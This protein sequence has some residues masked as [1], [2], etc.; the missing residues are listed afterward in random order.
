MRNWRSNLALSCLPAC[1]AGG[2]VFEFL[3]GVELPGE[4]R[5][6]LLKLLKFD[7]IQWQ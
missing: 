4:A 5:P 1:L 2:R 6:E 7:K 3:L